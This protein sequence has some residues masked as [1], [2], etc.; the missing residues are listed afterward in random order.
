[1][2]DQPAHRTTEPVANRSHRGLGENIR[3]Q[4]TCLWRCQS[5]LRSPSMR[6]SM[7]RPPLWSPISL[8][9]W[10]I[11]PTVASSSTCSLM[12]HWR[13]TAVAWS[14]SACKGQVLVELPGD[15]ALVLVGGLERGQWVVPLHGRRFQPPAKPRSAIAKMIVE[16]ASRG[17]F[18]VRLCLH[19]LRAPGI[20]SAFENAAI[21]RYSRALK[22]SRL[23]A[24]SGHLPFLLIMLVASP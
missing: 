19:P 12:N 20:L 7:N 23:F 3:R 21:D 22:N 8:I 13:K 1:M 16:S 10:T 18:P 14:F 2:H 17:R 11:P 6:S 24:D 15:L 9:L 4:S 5:A